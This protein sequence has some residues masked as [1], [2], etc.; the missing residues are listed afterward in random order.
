MAISPEDGGDIQIRGIPG[1]ILTA[2]MRL[3]FIIEVLGR[4]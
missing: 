3:T 1:S 2:E 4:L